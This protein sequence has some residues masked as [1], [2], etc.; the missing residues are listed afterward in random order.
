MSSTERPTKQEIEKFLETV[1]K[2]DMFYA[3]QKVIRSL[4]IFKDEKL[5]MPEFMKVMKYLK[6]IKEQ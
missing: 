3:E 4:D 5:P 1:G 6:A 2:L